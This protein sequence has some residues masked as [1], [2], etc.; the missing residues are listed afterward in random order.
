MVQAKQLHSSG[1]D[2]PPAVACAA[3]AG[4]LQL[5]S[6]RKYASTPGALFPSEG[7]LRWFLRSHAR[8]LGMAGALVRIRGRQLIDV[9][10]FEREVVEIGRQEARRIA[11][12]QSDDRGRE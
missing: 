5:K 3:P 4:R 7:S 10:P 11:M 12:A 9:A 2:S 8:A 6:I 1:G